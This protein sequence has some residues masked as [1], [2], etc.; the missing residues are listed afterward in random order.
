M[1]D[2][3]IDIYNENYELIGTELKSIAHEKGYWHQVFTCVIINS[4]SNKIY[5]QK[6]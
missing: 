6:K 5:F 2:H 4:I 3:L 1:A